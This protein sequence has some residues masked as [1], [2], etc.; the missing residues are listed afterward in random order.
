MRPTPQPPVPFVAGHQYTRE[1][2]FD[3]LGIE[4]RPK[5]G[6]WFTG[7]NSHGDDWYVF[8]HIE[9]AG[10]TG[11]DYGNAWEGSLLRWRGKTG[12]RL[13]HDSIQSMLNPEGR[14]LV[15]AREQDRG[16]FTFLGAAQAERS[17]DTVPV[18]IWWRIT[19]PANPPVQEDEVD[20]KTEVPN[21]GR[22]ADAG[23]GLGEPEDN[24]A[25]EVAAV[26]LATERYRSDGWDVASVESERIGYDLR[27]TRGSEERHVEVKGVSGSVPAFMLTEGERRRAATD[28]LWRVV[29]VTGALDPSPQCQEVTGEE[30][31]ANW[32]LDPVTWRVSPRSAQ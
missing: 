28:P 29:V 14:V 2:I 16:P 23:A 30:L 21:G 10:R 18:T 19:D 1:G 31:L 22:Q 6:N 25:V 13:H 12:S 27:C 17:A 8:T 32:Q 24:A 9:S 4:P 20:A 7:Y 3:I 11:H 15:F 5:G 26:A